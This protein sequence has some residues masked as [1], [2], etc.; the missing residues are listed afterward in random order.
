ML[1]RKTKRNNTTRHEQNDNNT[2]MDNNNT[3][4]TR[5][6][7]WTTNIMKKMTKKVK[8]TKGQL[9]LTIIVGIIIGMII[10]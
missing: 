7:N 2:N 10:W 9:A 4:Y 6:N 5:D 3:I 8:I 1:R